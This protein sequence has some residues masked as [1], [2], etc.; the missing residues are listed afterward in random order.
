[1]PDGD[2]VDKYHRGVFSNDFPSAANTLNGILMRSR[3]YLGSDGQT[4]G[5]CAA[6]IQR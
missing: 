5:D 6:P 1:M 2:G 4:L 3:S